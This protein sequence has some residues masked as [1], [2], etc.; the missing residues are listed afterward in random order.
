MFLQCKRI[1]KRDKKL[2][3]PRLDKI[4]GCVQ[5]VKYSFGG[6]EKSE[7]FCNDPPQRGKISMALHSI[8]KVFKSILSKTNSF[9][10]HEMLTKNK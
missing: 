3:F 10:E 8:R 7:S 4:R 6:K 1:F 2:L 9:S 5:L